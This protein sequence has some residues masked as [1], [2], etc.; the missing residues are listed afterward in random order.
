MRKRRSGAGWVVVVVLLAAAV[1]VG[2]YLAR[3]DT[4]PVPYIPVPVTQ[5]DPAAQESPPAHPIQDVLPQDQTEASAPLPE[6][7]DSDAAALAELA[8]LLGLEDPARVFV[9][10]H[11]IPRIVV[12]IDNLPRQRIVQRILPVRPAPGTLQVEQAD[13]MLWLAD[14]NAGRYEPFVAIAE[15]ADPDALA[16]AYVR[17]YPLFQRAYVELGYPDG[18][19]NDRL[20]EV[21]DHLLAAPTPV[22]PLELQRGQRGYV[23]VDPALEAAS[24]GH[25]LMFRLSAGQADRMKVVLREFRARVVAHERGEEP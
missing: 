17:A 13:G 19:F 4:A 20:V 15:S 16:A 10:G 8:R 24:V 2:V 5:P 11:L 14:A 1:A 6:L 23:Y 22:R 12:T 7:E 3:R 18:Y 25:K 9:A 21:I